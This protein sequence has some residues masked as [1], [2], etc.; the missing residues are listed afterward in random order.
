MG[1]FLCWRVS[2]DSIILKSTRTVPLV[3]EE[4]RVEWPH[5]CVSNIS[6]RIPVGRIVLCVPGWTPV[7]LYLT[8]SQSREQR[9][10]RR[11]K[12]RRIENWG[13][14]MTTE[15][16]PM[17]G[18]RNTFCVRLWDSRSPFSLSWWEERCR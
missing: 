11:E 5:R 15:Y 3:W 16:L 6:L 13:G 2:H 10:E 9:E 7:L 1:S 17:P 14:E 18:M 12:E 8:G 4:R